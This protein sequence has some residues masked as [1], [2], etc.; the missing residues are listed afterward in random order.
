[1]VEWENAFRRAFASLPRTAGRGAEHARDLHP[2]MGPA[3]LGSSVRV[4]VLFDGQSPGV[5]HGV[6]IDEQG[7]GTLIEQR[8]YQL[9]RQ[10]KPIADRQF[11]IEFFSSGWRPLSSPSADSLC[12]PWSTSC[13]GQNWVKPIRTSGRLPVIGRA[14]A[15]PVVAPFPRRAQLARISVLGGKP[16]VLN[17]RARREKMTQLRHW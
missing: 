6:D 15:C 13:P 2:V 8:L 10:P 9:I 1:M 16:D 4:R 3:A 11:E 17:Q 14:T 7:C 5:A 12:G